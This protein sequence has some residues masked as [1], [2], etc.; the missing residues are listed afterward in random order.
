MDT[1]NTLRRVC[2][3]KCMRTTGIVEPYAKYTT[4]CNSTDFSDIRSGGDVGIGWE[5]RGCVEG[6]AGVSKR[7]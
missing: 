5:A 2:P 4:E 3:E 7:N 6:A 1:Y